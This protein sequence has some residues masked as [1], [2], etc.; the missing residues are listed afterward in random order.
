MTTPRKFGPRIILLLSLTTAGSLVAGTWWYGQSSDRTNPSTTPT[1]TVAEDGHRDP[2]ASS[3]P[4]GDSPSPD[5]RSGVAK[6][7]LRLDGSTQLVDHGNTHES[8]V[9]KHQASTQGVDAETAGAFVENDERD[10]PLDLQVPSSLH[11]DTDEP[12]VDEA[13]AAATAEPN[14]LDVSEFREHAPEVESYNLF[15][16]EYG[17]RGFM[18]QNWINQRVALQGGLGL[19]D[20]RL[21]KTDSD[22]R[23]DIAFGMGLI[24][25]F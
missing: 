6:L 8:R 23:D 4:L 3:P 24:V 20:D 15:K 7:E 14:P 12:S 22:F 10:D 1:P 19:N 18:K 21:I 11:G 25:A 16:S 17:L 9:R 13:V 2:A 5:T